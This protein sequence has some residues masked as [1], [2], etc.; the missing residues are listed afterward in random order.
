MSASPRLP[1][2]NEGPAS[3]DYNAPNGAVSQILYP[4]NFSCSQ[5]LNLSAGYL[6]ISGTEGKREHL[7]SLGKEKKKHTQHRL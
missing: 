1:G 4:T 2:M 7:V 5:I 3:S 6:I